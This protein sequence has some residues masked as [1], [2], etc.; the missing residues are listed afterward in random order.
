MSS[1][2]FPHLFSPFSIG[3]VTFKNRIF[4]TGHDTMLAEHGLVGDALV[5]YHAA[6]ADGGVG[7]IVVQAAA[8]HDSARYTAHVL[9][10]TS[11]Q[12]IAGYRRIVE[13]CGARDCRVIAQLFHPGR[14]VMD[15]DEGALRV[16]YAPSATRSD[17]FHVIPRAMS[18]AMIDEIMEGYAADARRMAKAGVD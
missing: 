10:L 1:K 17:R 18:L 12:C 2:A 4:S 14:E 5:A 15:T 3:E 13:V 8:I 6:R 16:A 9:M 7:L 11:D